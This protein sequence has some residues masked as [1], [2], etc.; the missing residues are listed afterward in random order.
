METKPFKE[1]ANTYAQRAVNVADELKN[2]FHLMA[3]MS[4]RH[5]L[6]FQFKRVVGKLNDL[7]QLLQFIEKEIN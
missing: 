5:A 4:D 2:E 7:K 6:I 3:S 1:S